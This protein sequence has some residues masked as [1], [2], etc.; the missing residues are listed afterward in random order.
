MYTAV[1][2][3][4]IC[5]CSKCTLQ[6]VYLMYVVVQSVHCSVF[7]WYMLLFRVHCLLT[8]V[9]SLGTLSCP[10]C[11]T[12]WRAGQSLSCCLATLSL[13][14]LC[15][16]FLSLSLSL[17]LSGCA[18]FISPESFCSPFLFLFPLWSLCLFHIFQFSFSSLHFWSLCLCCF[19][20]FLLC[21]SL[22]DFSVLYL[23]SVVLF[24]LSMN[25]LSVLSKPLLSLLSQNF[26]SLC[27][28]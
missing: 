28:L 4:D 6:C 20:V 8:E 18:V 27:S 11:Y 7:I 22:H 13:S 1:S 26:F 10:A 19:S 24:S 16:L 21:L 15:T 17:S 25:S 2:L 5:F 14:V 3:C 12:F 9:F 23:F